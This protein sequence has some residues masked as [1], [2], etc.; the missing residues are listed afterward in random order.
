VHAYAAGE[1][2]LQRKRERYFFRLRSTTGNP[3]FAE[4][5]KDLAKG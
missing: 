1:L 4:C 3:I 5:K 2:E